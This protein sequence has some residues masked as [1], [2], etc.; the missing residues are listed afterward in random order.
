[1]INIITLYHR[2]KVKKIYVGKTTFFFVI[3]LHIIIPFTKLESRAQAN[4]ADVVVADEVAADTPT[5]EVSVI[6]TEAIEL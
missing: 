4:I 2:F 1:M 5:V 6:R 3:I